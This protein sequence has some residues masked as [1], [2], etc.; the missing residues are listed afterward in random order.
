MTR[1]DITY[2]LSTLHKKDMD[3]VLKRL[4]PEKKV[5]VLRLLDKCQAE[6]SGSN[7][8]NPDQFWTSIQSIKDGGDSEAVKLA[9]VVVP[10]SVV[11]ALA[12]SLGEST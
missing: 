8:G 12:E 4:A 3:W 10:P 6:R 2:I 9:G 1:T 5:K 11:K 7:A